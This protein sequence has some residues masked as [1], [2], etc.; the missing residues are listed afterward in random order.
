MFF[1]CPAK[2]AR[3]IRGIEEPYP[4]KIDTASIKRALPPPIK[5]YH[6]KR[7][8]EVVTFHLGILNSLSVTRPKH[9]II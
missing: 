1:G 4:H 3:A 6:L 7:S 8:V 2:M 9:G 5:P